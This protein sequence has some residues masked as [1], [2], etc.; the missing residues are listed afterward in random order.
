VVGIALALACGDAL[1][2]DDMYPPRTGAPS[3]QVR[4]ARIAAA[5]A[6]LCQRQRDE[7]RLA[8]L[9]QFERAVDAADS[10]REPTT[11]TSPVLPR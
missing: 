10:A 1:A 5:G 2:V 6:E 8:C 3:A 9:D 11:D 4:A 7:A